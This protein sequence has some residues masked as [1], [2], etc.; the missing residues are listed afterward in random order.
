MEIHPT[1]A[2]AD[3]AIIGE[4]VRI[5]PY[6][7]IGEE[8]TIGPETVIGSHAVIDKYTT[9]GAGCQIYPHTVIGG[10]PQDLKYKGEKTVL[11]LGDNN[12]VRE[13]TTLNRGTTDGTGET[14][15]GNNNYFMAYSHVAH[16]CRIGD[17]TIFANCATL[18]GHITIED[19]VIIG[20]LTPIHQFTRVG[21]YAIVGGS[22]AVS[23]D[24][25]PFALASGRRAKIYGINKV[26]LKR[27][28]FSQETRSALKHAF[29]IIFHSNLNTTHALEKVSEEIQGC[30][31]V[32]YLVKFIK[33]TKRGISK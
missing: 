17:H 25:V 19:H 21:K 18:A 6:A 7:V 8:I 9:I 3:D 30:E 27:H 4:N 32:D 14:I 12:V 24:I 10:P 5:G 1:A 13:F 20:G 2:I 29:R 31:E 23:K 26:G 15:I 28:G 16:D 11:K 22:S 33:E